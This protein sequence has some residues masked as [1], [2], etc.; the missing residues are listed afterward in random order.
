MNTQTVKELA[1]ERHRYLEMY[2]KQFYKEWEFAL[3]I[4]TIKD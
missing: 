3:V 1:V 4:K 2:L